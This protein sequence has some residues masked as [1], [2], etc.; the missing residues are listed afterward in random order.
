MSDAREAI[1][2]LQVEVHHLTEAVRSLD[3][4]MDAL[5]AQAN[6]W[7]GAFLV[8]LSFGAAI[9]WLIDRMVNLIARP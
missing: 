5:T 4:K 9:G 8:V 6:R 1:A 7:K 2:A 3:K